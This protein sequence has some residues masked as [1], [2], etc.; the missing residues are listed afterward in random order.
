MSRGRCRGTLLHFYLD[1]LGNYSIFMSNVH[2]ISFRI[3]IFK[4]EHCGFLTVIIKIVHCVT[5]IYFD[6]LAVKLLEK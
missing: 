4:E 2:I 5:W 3:N 1:H 6:F